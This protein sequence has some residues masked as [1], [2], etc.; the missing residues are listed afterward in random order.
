[1]F[2]DPSCTMPIGLSAA[3]DSGETSNPSPADPTHKATGPDQSPPPSFY[4]ASGVQGDAFEWDGNTVRFRLV[5]NAPPN[6]TA[7][8]RVWVKQFDRDSG[9][10]YDESGREIPTE[11]FEPRDTD[12]MISGPTQVDAGRVQVEGKP[13][14][15]MVTFTAIDNDNDTY[16]IVYADPACKQ[17]LARSHV[18]GTNRGAVKDTQPIK[19]A[20]GVSGFGWSGNQLSFRV[21]PPDTPKVWAKLFDKDSGFDY[22]TTGRLLPGS[23]DEDEQYGGVREVTV[24]DGKATVAATGDADDG[25][26]YAIVYADPGCTVPLARSGVKG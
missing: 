22:D 11:F 12:T 24:R 1:V 10:D 14:S 5:D 2:A 15:E 19:A 6:P 7:T 4:A 23:R 17:P 16:V 20:S 3:R 8:I 18:Q 13:I 26:T 25:D 9:Y 21:D